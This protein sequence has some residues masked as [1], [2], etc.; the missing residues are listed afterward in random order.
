M[1]ARAC[2]VICDQCGNPAEISTEG[3]NFARRLARAEGFSYEVVH[4]EHG[5]TAG[6][7]LCGHCNSN[8]VPSQRQAEADLERQG[9]RQTI[10]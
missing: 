7:D 10:E 4:G 3:A 2:Y 9:Q 1:I 5:S 8:G 6:R